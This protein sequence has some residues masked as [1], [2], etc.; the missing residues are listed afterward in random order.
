MT[1]VN[2][3]PRLI[4]LTKPITGTLQQ[5]MAP[6]TLGRFWKLIDLTIMDNFDIE[7]LQQK[8]HIISNKFINAEIWNLDT[9]INNND[10]CLIKFALFQL[11]NKAVLTNTDY[12]SITVIE[13]NVKPNSTSIAIYNYYT[14]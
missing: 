11:G 5:A 6:V 1:F 10:K 9:I 7:I 12:L 14:P 3:F 8:P 2:N 13:S 4:D